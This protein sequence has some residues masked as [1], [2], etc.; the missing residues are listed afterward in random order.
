MK[1][2]RWLAALLLPLLLFTLSCSEKALPT[3]VVA[4]LCEVESD[5]PIGTLYSY[6]V[7]SSDAELIGDKM[8]CA[9]FGDGKLPSV[10]DEVESG[11][12]YLSP[13]HPYEITLFYTKS[14]DGAKKVAQMCLLRKEAIIRAWSGKGYD[15][16]L[17]NAEVTVCGRWVMLSVSHDAK[18][19]AHRLDRLT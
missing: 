8:L 17:Q 11:A 9:M 15:E 4:A 13:T 10:I 6:R 16:Y 3:D 2:K 19:L 14:R 12:F 5:H 18:E 1:T 7:S